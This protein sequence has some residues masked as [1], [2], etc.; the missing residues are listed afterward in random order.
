M[1]GRYLGQLA[2]VLARLALPNVGV[3]LYDGEYP[4][5]VRYLTII[6]LL[7]T[8]C[9]PLPRLLA[10]DRI[11]GNEAMVIVT[12]AFVLIACFPVLFPLPRVAGRSLRQSSH[13]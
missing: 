5:S 2:L 6:A 13:S 11:Q 3:S 7:G 9:W 1:L 4:I 10:P 8:A 12:L